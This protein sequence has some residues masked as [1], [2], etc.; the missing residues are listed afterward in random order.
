[1]AT[2]ETGFTPEKVVL[3]CNQDADPS[4]LAARRSLLRVAARWMHDFGS[5]VL[6]A[7]GDHAVREQSAELAWAL[8][9]EFEREGLNV[10]LRFRAQPRSNFPQA[11]NAA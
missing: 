6:V 1:M 2:L 8:S 10:A 4:T 11:M 5:V 9:D 7:D 3:V